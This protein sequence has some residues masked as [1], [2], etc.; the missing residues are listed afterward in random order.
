MPGYE[1]SLLAVTSSL[2][3]R[4]A[5][6]GRLCEL[7]ARL[8]VYVTKRIAQTVYYSILAL[9][10]RPAELNTCR[11]RKLLTCATPLL[12]LACKTLALAPSPLVG[13]EH[14]KNL[15]KANCNNKV[16][17]FRTSSRDIFCKLLTH[18]CSPRYYKDGL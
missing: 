13:I 4:P 15:A 1:A 3:S 14:R 8:I 7:H 18:F 17:L 6:T 9:R 10:L 2:L 5:H 12:A 16:E 11:K